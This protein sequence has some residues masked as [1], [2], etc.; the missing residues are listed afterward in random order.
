MQEK[1]YTKSILREESEYISMAAL[2]KLIFGFALIGVCMVGMLMIISQQ[3]STPLGVANIGNMDTFINTSS[4][5]NQ[6]GLV[7][8]TTT[9][10]S[11]VGILALFIIAA[12][13]IIASVALISGRRR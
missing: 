10:G 11:T 5:K 3:M 1:V 7:S 13:V 12:L 4:A 8:T 9:F 2:E 6:T